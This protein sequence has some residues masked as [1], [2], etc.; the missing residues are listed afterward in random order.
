MKLRICVMVCLISSILFLAGVTPAF[1]SASAAAPEAVQG[2]LD[3]REDEFTRR[4]GWTILN[5]EWAFYWKELLEPHQVEASQDKQYVRVP[6]DWKRYNLKGEPPLSNYGYATYRLEILLPEGNGKRLHAL[7]MPSVATAYRL[8][9]DGEPAGGRGTVGISREEMV[10]KNAPQVYVF[11]PKSERVEIVLQVS[12]FVQRKGGMWEEIRFGH[13]EAIESLRH[14]SIASEIGVFSAIFFMGIYHLGLYFYRRS[15]RSPLYFGLMCLAVGVRMLFLGETLAVYAFPSIPWE[16]GVK[17][18]YIAGAIGITC[19]L[20]FARSQYPEES[21]RWV[22]QAS[23]GF[24]SVLAVFVAAA[25]AHVYT[26]YYTPIMIAYLLQILYC[27][28]IY[29]T[30]AFRRRAGSVLNLIGFSILTGTIVNDMLFY[31][32]QQKFGNVVHFGLFAALFTQSLHLAA[33]FTKA[34]QQSETLATQLKQMNETLEARVCQRTQALREANERLAE[35]NQALS[36]M[37]QSR[38]QLLTTIS[39]E[40]G[41]PLT[42]IQGYVKLMLEGVVDSKDHR[43]LNLIYDKTLFLD[44]MIHD[45][46]ELSKL[47]AK[48]L[49]FHFQRIPASSFLRKLSEGYLPIGKEAGI[50]VTA[51]EWEAPPLPEEGGEWYLRIDAVRIEQVFANFISNA[52]KFTPESGSIHIGFETLPPGEVGGCYSVK[53]KVTDTGVGMEAGELPRV[54]ERFYKGISSTT[55]RSDGA[56]LGLAIAKQIVEQHGGIIG[57]DSILNQGSTFYFI[58]PLEWGGGTE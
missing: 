25:P 2:I 43:V 39:H 28:Y 14:R 10:P 46:F 17:V 37:E 7:Y 35:R 32:Q 15:D 34:Y 3:L 29:I 30:A 44:R 51:E 24:T 31:T 26:E 57:V 6:N 21:R 9:I 18:E 42:S 4:N 52:K 1:A 22:K 20:S 33:R 12:N 53:V 40:L 8:W 19:F 54:F 27:A 50:T 49:Q 58:L 45:L 5:G 23:I 48:A 36:E 13:A 55:S 41:N 16:F 47:E 38:R 11:L 56:G